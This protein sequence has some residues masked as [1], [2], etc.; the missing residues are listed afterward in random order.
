MCAWVCL[1]DSAHAAW[2][3]QSRKV[4]WRW[5][6]LSWE[7]VAGE[8]PAHSFGFREAGEWETF[9]H[10]TPVGHSRA[11]GMYTLKSLPCLCQACLG[12]QGFRKWERRLGG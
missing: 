11:L 9:S 1:V 8:S 5:W 3:I 10:S 2:D 12:P 6:L 7:K 4:S